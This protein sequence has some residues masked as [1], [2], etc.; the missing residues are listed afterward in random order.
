M[1]RLRAAGSQRPIRALASARRERAAERGSGSASPREVKLIKINM[2]QIFQIIGS[3]ILAAIP[4]IIWGNIF[5][6][7]SPERRSFTF[8]TFIMGA[9]AVFP[10]LI[11]KFSW[12][13]FP[14]MNAFKFANYY[15]NDIIGFS[16]AIIL[17]LSIIITFMIV[18]VI[19]ETMKFSSVKIVD[20][21]EIKNIDDSIEFF[22]LAALGFAF[23][24]NILYFYN[25]WIV[26]GPSNLLLP[27]LFRS[28]FST[29]AHLLFSGL[30]GY[31]YGIAHFATTILQ[32]EMRAKNSF[33]ARIPVKL[34]FFKRETFFYQ[35]KLLEGMI[36]AV[37]LHALF[38]IFLEMGLTFMIVPFLVG[39]YVTLTYLLDLKE[40]HKNYGKLL[41]YVR[42]HPHKSGVYFQ[43][44][45]L[46]DAIK[47]N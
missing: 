45:P 13:F 37:G 35:E 29:F 4:A 14:W 11:Y 25:I 30:L 15:R 2:P 23:T 19:E 17:P 3:I 16:H 38:N 44:N 40:N 32:E 20:D 43:R 34:L 6:H 41:N 36:F 18:G 8:L 46:A 42:N 5:F 39:G 27:F 1:L 31:Y 7:K 47:P 10:I 26:E 24:E 22:I 28:C 12:Q 33:W 21:D 9:L